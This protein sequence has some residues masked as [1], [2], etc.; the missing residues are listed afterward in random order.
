GIHSACAVSA[1]QQTEYAGPSS[2]VDYD[3]VGLDGTLQGERV[4]THPALIRDHLAITGN[5]IH[6]S[7]GLLSLFLAHETRKLATG[8]GRLIIA[9]AWNVGIVICS[10]LTN[11]LS[12]LPQVA[13]HLHLRGKIW[14]SALF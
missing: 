12:D 8:S 5:A 14:F 13:I 2:D 1:C 3:R 10:T 7:I 9:V 4:R 11:V 6:V